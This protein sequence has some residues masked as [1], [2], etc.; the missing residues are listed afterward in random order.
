MPVAPHPD[1]QNIAKEA[2]D[3][4]GS[5][6]MLGVP[7]PRAYTSLQY[8]PVVVGVLMDGFSLEDMEHAL[9]QTEAA[10][11]RREPFVTVR[12]LRGAGRPPS[13]LQRARVAAWQT[14]WKDYAERYCVGVATLTDS[15]LMRGALQAYFWT[16]P[17]V[18]PEAVF[19]TPREASPWLKECLRKAHVT[20]PA[21]LDEWEKTNLAF[22]AAPPYPRDEAP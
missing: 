13:A 8:F 2:K 14:E 21:L 20:P 17:P 22:P 15:V 11:L 10:F 19:A 6:G 5:G 7:V 1:S 3:R 9:A 16:F 4:R 12:D 18:M